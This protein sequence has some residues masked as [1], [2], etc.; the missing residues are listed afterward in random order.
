MLGAAAPIR[1][2]SSTTDYGAFLYASFE[3]R[4]LKKYCGTLYNIQRHD[5]R[6]LT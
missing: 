3:H 2:T 1:F 5:S 4:F 6:F